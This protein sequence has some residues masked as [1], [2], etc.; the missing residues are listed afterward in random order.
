ML[1]ISNQW[2]DKHKPFTPPLTP[3][4]GEGNKL[5]WVLF[6]KATK[7]PCG[8]TL[9]HLLHPDAPSAQFARLFHSLAGDDHARTNIIATP[10]ETAG[11]WPD[12]KGHAHFST[13]SSPYK[14]EG[15]SVHLF[16]T[17]PDAEAAE[18]TPVILHDC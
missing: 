16:I 15:L 17:H 3:I 8:A 10:A 12:F 2:Q 7:G 1:L 11:L 4:L 14:S 13:H 18:D 5:K 9:W 6:A